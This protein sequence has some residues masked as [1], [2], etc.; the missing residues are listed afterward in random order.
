MENILT[1]VQEIILKRL[2]QMDSK[3]KEYGVQQYGQARATE[4]DKRLMFETLTPQKLGQLIREH[5]P[6]VVNEWLGSRM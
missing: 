3:L 4:K 5:G 2:N 6:D 1:Q